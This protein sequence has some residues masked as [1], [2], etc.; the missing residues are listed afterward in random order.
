MVSI[1]L[2]RIRAE[3]S[4]LKF[5]RTVVLVIAAVLFFAGWLVGKAFL[6]V[7]AALTWSFAA[8]K[9]GFLD[10]RNPRSR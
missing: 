3:A 5:W 8:A 6:L 10:A 9:I 4:Q 7:W 2:E 1:P